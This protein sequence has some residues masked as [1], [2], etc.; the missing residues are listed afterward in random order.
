M[1]RLLLN[2]T[3]QIKVPRD[4]G[5][6]TRCPMECR[7]LSSNGPWSC[8]VSIRWEYNA[9]GTRKDKIKEETFGG[10]LTEKSEVEM[11]LRRAQAAV[12][13]PKTERSR[14]L[15]MTES[16]L[17]DLSPR[18]KKGAI[19]FSQN[20]V[21]IDI[22]GPDLTDL[23]FVDLPGLYPPSLLV[24]N[25]VFTHVLHHCQVSYKMPKTTLYG[26]LSKWSG[27]TFLGLV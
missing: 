25:G 16:E 27:R 13:N 8:Q 9:D 10:L 7:L 21:C 6:C 23:S 26:S 14:F 3:K 18:D 22:A 11:V 2:G 15:A 12:L 19:P 5:T 20:V 17:N 4:A 1:W 24:L